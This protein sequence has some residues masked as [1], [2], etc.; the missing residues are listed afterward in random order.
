MSLS[1]TL[2]LSELNQ[3][4]IF[5]ILKYEP[6]LGYAI[7]DILPDYTR[8]SMNYYIDKI[9]Y[10]DIPKSYLT[11]EWIRLIHSMKYLSNQQKS[12][13]IQN[14]IETENVE[15]LKWINDNSIEV[16]GYYIHHAL[17]NDKPKTLDYFMKK[18]YRITND[19]RYLVITAI[20]C[21][22]MNC[23][24]Y[25]YE[26]YLEDFKK[27]DFNSIIFEAVIAHIKYRTFLWLEEKKRNGMIDYSIE[28]SITG[29]SHNSY[30]YGGYSSLEKL[31]IN[32]DSDFTFW[33]IRQMEEKYQKTRGGPYSWISPKYFDLAIEMC[34]I[35][36]MNYYYE[37]SSDVKKSFHSSYY[38]HNK[39]NVYSRVNKS[40]IRLQHEWLYQK[41]II[42]D[43]TNFLRSF[44]TKDI[45]LIDWI[46]HELCTERQ[47][48][49]LKENMFHGLQSNLYVISINLE[50]IQWFNKNDF[51]I[52]F[53]Y[54]LKY[55]PF[56]TIEWFYQNI[57][58]HCEN[59]SFPQR[60][61]YNS[62]KLYDYDS[63]KLI[64]FVFNCPNIEINDDFI[65]FIIFYFIHFHILI[66]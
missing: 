59:I 3:D 13:V 37:H 44:I 32:Y 31:S 12:V 51:V 50:M 4:L 17:H 60:V 34:N 14:C 62:C 19:I 8:K 1:N 22:S 38:M 26:N 45:G 7:Y 36:L 9:G 11:F 5:E 41:D 64:E 16:D 25:F 42:Y 20:E 15:A 52:H 61:C 40:M 49:E 27:I 24:D 57:F 58:D 28:Y 66:N 10:R 48:Q 65:K 53:D 33:I 54:L 2:T 18:R 56:E 35:P 21:D 43:C 6:Y 46:F 47:R 23:L 63:I 29:R 39:Y 30:S 55:S